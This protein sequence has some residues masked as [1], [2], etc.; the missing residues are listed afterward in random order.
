MGKITLRDEYVDPRTEQG[1]ISAFAAEPDSFFEH[2]PPET[3]FEALRPEYE[4]VRDQI[5]AGA[6]PNVTDTWDPADDPAAAIARLQALHTRRRMAEVQEIL[7]TGLSGDA[8][9]QEVLDRASDALEAAR[10]ELTTEGAGEI[11]PS[12]TVL[13]AVVADAKEAREHYKRTGSS[14]RGVTSGI[15]ALDT[16]TGGF[17]PG[18]TLLAGGPGVGKTTLALQ[19]A[20]EA[21][22]DDV[23]VVYVTFENSPEALVR[24]G[25]GATGQMNPR[26]I[27][28]GT[29]PLQDMLEAAEAWQQKTRPLAF[30]EG[31]SDL[32]TG[33]ITGKVRRHMNTFGAETGLVVVDYLQLYAKAA[34]ELDG[35]TLRERVERM[36][37]RL[38]EVSMR[39]RVPVL[40]IASQNRGA[41][42]S[43]GGRASLDTL[44]ESGDLEYGADVV[45][46]LTEPA[47]RMATD[48]AKALDLT[49][50]KNRNGETGHLPMIFR[51]DRSTMHPE[52]KAE[53]NT[54]F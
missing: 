40:A 34:A 35:H 42:Y 4:R 18:L 8:G 26:G 32:S 45:M 7:A 17:Q 49:V 29:T 21:A 39:L 44:K 36:G 47:D 28:R 5:E 37:Q 14:I 20:A 51:P 22:A 12:Q 54:P 2:Q 10:G 13:E 3:L 19:M 1:L 25:I 27:L 46:I 30:I 6:D 48:P 31:R 9:A 52:A 53:G 41:K 38:R 23:A 16:I 24:K 50:A 43:D 15:K 11:L 33:A